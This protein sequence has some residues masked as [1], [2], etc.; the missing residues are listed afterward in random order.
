MDYP[1]CALQRGWRGWRWRGNGL[2]FAETSWQKTRTERGDRDR[3]SPPRFAS[4]FCL[5]VCFLFLL[6]LFPCVWARQK[7][8]LNCCAAPWLWSCT[9]TLWAP[10]SATMTGTQWMNDTLLPEQMCTAATA[11]Q[12]LCCYSSEFAA[13][14]CIS[15]TAELLHD[16][17]S[18]R[19]FC[20]KRAILFLISVNIQLKSIGSLLFYGFSVDASRVWTKL[21]RCAKIIDLWRREMP[22]RSAAAPN[23][24]PAETF[25]KVI[26]FLQNKETAVI[27][28]TSVVG[29]G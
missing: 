12:C 13:C 23:L 18:A 29:L 15:I 22:P 7:C 6:L 19:V 28:F 20:Y 3:D 11:S 4:L 2:V 1:L 26:F 14:L 5:F 16:Q 8:L 17:V 21:H 27:I 25:S 24:Q 10:I 9:S